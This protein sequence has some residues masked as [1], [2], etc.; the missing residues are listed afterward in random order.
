L[1]GIKYRRRIVYGRDYAQRPARAE[2][3][4]AV[5]PYYYLRVSAYKTAVVNVYVGDN[6]AR[7]ELVGIICRTAVVKDKPGKGIAGIRGS[8]YLSSRIAL[9]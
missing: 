1:R 8:Y 9:V 7:A 4:L 6:H 2:R 5:C 3:G